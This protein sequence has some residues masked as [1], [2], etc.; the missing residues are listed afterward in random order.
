MAVAADLHRDFLILALRRPAAG[1]EAA[2]A[3]RFTLFFCDIT[4]AFF[5]SFVNRELPLCLFYEKRE[6][7]K[8]Q[9]RKYDLQCF[10]H[11]FVLQWKK[12]PAGDLP[13]NK[14]KA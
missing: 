10:S 5:P 4:I 1:A 9:Y 8:M 2:K 11:P 12:I 6:K 7:E 3:A 13:A 14:R